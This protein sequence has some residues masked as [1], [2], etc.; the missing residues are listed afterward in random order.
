MLRDEIAAERDNATAGGG[1]AS[2]PLPR[3]ASLRLKRHRSG[4][5]I[6]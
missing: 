4:G 6:W 2:T 1:L 5:R 3:F